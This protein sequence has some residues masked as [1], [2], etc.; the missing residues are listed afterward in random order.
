MLERRAIWLEKDPSLLS[1]LISDLESLNSELCKITAPLA[2]CALSLK[3]KLMMLHLPMTS[4]LLSHLVDP[5]R[6][7]FKSG[8]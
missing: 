7:F 5:D 1:A 8:C 6:L 3:P 4:L 2:G